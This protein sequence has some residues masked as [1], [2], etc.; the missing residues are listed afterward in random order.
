MLR[1][2]ICVA[3]R[4]ASSRHSEWPLR[5]SATHESREQAL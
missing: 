1:Q 5:S 2:S 4:V 3:D